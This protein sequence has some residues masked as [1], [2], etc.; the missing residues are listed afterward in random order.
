MPS[1][2]LLAAIAGQSLAELGPVPERRGP[3]LGLGRKPT[4]A[5]THLAAPTLPALLVGEPT[6]DVPLTHDGST[7]SA[8]QARTGCPP[9]LGTQPSV[10]PD[11]SPRHRARAH[12]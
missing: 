3:R 7:S 5:L 8:R 11:G 9:N 2:A 4:L 12:A 6:L 10:R 1:V